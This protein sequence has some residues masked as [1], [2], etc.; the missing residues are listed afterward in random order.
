MTLPRDRPGMVCGRTPARPGRRT[1]ADQPRGCSGSRR[2]GA[3]GLLR[4][5][6]PAHGQ[7]PAQPIS[8]P[9]AQGRAGYRRARCPAPARS[10]PSR[11]TSSPTTT[12]PPMRG[13]RRP[14]LTARQTLGTGQG[15]QARHLQLPG[16]QTGYLMRS[17]GSNVNDMPRS[18]NTAEHRHRA[19]GMD[20]LG[21]SSSELQRPKACRENVSRQRDILRAYPELALADFNADQSRPF[22]ETN[23][24][25]E[26]LMVFRNG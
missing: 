2:S 7:R 18:E 12:P 16:L 10:T 9:R 6:G 5:A 19:A 21:P 23:Y 1:S 24:E 26:V 17:S 15:L 14:R 3:T 11:T 13:Q 22:R 4:R 20:A 25:P 8:T